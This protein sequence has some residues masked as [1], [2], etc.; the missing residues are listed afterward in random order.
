[1]VVMSIL[2]TW[3]TFTCHKLIFLLPILRGCSHKGFENI[4]KSLSPVSL[5]SLIP[6]GI[7]KKHTKDTYY[8]SPHAMDGSESMFVSIYQQLEH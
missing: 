4:E 1:M 6:R 7:K 2:T 3:N 8:K 5:C